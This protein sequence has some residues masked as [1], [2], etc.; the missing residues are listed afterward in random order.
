M[1]RLRFDRAVAIQTAVCRLDRFQCCL[2]EV[3]S[4]RGGRKVNQRK[5]CGQSLHVDNVAAR[6]ENG[7]YPASRLCL[8]MRLRAKWNWK[9]VGVTFEMTIDFRAF[10]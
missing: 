6:G 5:G 10:A 8:Q 1:E 7:R 9:V 4:S 3:G 2:K